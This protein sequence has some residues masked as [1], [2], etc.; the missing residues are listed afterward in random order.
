MAL[1]VKGW[2]NVS[3][4][5]ALVSVWVQG[6]GGGLVYSD[7]SLPSQPWFISRSNLPT[8]ANIV[9]TPRACPCIVIANLFRL[10]PTYV[11]SVSFGDVH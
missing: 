7:L 1:I 11:I 9:P 6:G 3:I 8:S 10:H 2:D 4:S 5:G